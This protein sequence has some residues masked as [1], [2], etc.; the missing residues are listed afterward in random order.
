MSVCS[1]PSSCCQMKKEDFDLP[2]ANAT[3]DGGLVCSS[4]VMGSGVMLGVCFVY[5]KLPGSTPNSG[6]DL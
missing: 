4:G 3:Q 6:S 1:C 2:V 5:S